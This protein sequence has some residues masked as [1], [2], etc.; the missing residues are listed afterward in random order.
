MRSQKKYSGHLALGLLALLI[1]SFGLFNASAHIISTA[2]FSQ[3]QVEL[4]LEQ[5][6]SES[7]ICLS[8]F[9]SR[10]YCKSSENHYSSFIFNTTYLIGYNTFIFV[11]HQSQSEKLNSINPI[12]HFTQLK[13]IPQNSDDP[14]KS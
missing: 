7:E 3:A 11:K 9:Y 6:N 8:S 2:Q 10:S 5:K 4:T 12:S 13:R 1:I 14:S